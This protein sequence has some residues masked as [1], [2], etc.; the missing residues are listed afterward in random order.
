MA[1]SS[2]PHPPRRGLL[3]LVTVIAASLAFVCGLATPALARVVE[4]HPANQAFSANMTGWSTS[5][6]ATCT[7]VLVPLCSVTPQH[8]A[9][10]GNPAGALQ[11]RFTSLVT[12]LNVIGGTG[13]FTSDPFTVSQPSDS[14]ELRIDRLAQVADLL[15]LGG[16]VGWRVRLLDLTTPA[17]SQ[18]LVD[19]PVLVGDAAWNSRVLPV[20]TALVAGHQY[21]IAIQT[22]FSGTL[23]AIQ[24]WDVFYDNVALQLEV[25]ESP[26]IGTPVT[27]VV[28]ATGATLGAQVD[29]RGHA[30]TVHVEWGVTTA[31]GQQTAPQPIGSGSSPVAATADLSGLA[32]GTT[33]HYR[34]V[35][36]SLEGTTEGPDLTFTTLDP[37]RVTGLGTAAAAD[38]FTV[39]GQIDPRGF[40]TTYRVEYGTSASYGAQTAP[41]PAG[42]GTGDVPLSAPVTGLAPGTTYHWR[43]VATS[44]QGTFTGPDRT[45]TTLAPP[46]A[47]GFSSTPAEDRFTAHA[48]VDAN[49]VATT[50]TIEY[51]ATTAYGSTAP[52]AP[53]SGADPV[54]VDIPVTGLAAGTTYHWRVVAT[55]ADGT[56]TGPDQTVTTLAPPVI[57]APS[58]TRAADSFTARATIDPRGHA[59]TYRIEWGIGD[60]ANSTAAVAVP[61]PGQIAETVSGLASGTTYRWRVVA[62]SAQGTVVGATQTVT[63]LAP[64]AISALGE[65]A[66]TDQGFTASFAVD[67]R[68]AAA[69]VAVEYGTTAAYGQTAAADVAGTGPVARTVPISGLTPGTVIHWRV[70]AESAEGRTEGPDRTVTTLAPPVLS[71]FDAT[72]GALSFQATLQVDA[73]GFGTEV[74]V[75]YGTTPSYGAITGPVDAGDGGSPVAVSVPVTGLAQ[76]TTYHWRAVATSSQGT[77]TGPDQTVATI[78][79][80]APPA[81]GA[82]SATPG[83]G[84]FIASGSVDP[85]GHLTDVRVEYGPTAAYGA[86][87]DPVEAGSGAGPVG[88]EVPV[89]GLVPG[90]V[91]HWRIV[92][93]SAEGTVHGPDQTVTTLAPPAGLAP[94][95]PIPGPP[96][97]GGDPG[98]GTSPPAP[99]APMTPFGRCTIVGTDGP[100]RLTGTPGRDI[101]CGLGGG[102]VIRGLGGGD[103]IFGDAG[104]DVIDGGAGHDIIR[105]G[106]GR[107]IIAGGAGDDRILGAAGDDRLR[108]GAGRDRLDG[109]AG[110]DAVDGGAGN[111]QLVGGAGR[112]LLRGGAGDD[113][114]LGRAGDDR[115]EGGPGVDL[116]MGGPGDDRLIG[117]P[118][119]DRLNGGPGR[120][121]AVGAAGERL[122]IRVERR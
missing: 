34:V 72:P 25:D 70:V 30:T 52:G 35:A 4:T 29:P 83:A 42:S 48:T 58:S 31:Y 75:E 41:V 61:G 3:R 116:L 17:L 7:V 18:T 89:A 82:F 28:G 81:L 56:F 69:S 73:R 106:A 36:T 23:S 95:G 1:S 32:P 86:L 38:G 64:P 9:A 93:E 98:A 54:A 6:A 100:D 66:V 15:S 37:P 77:V 24:S 19:E 22:D 91:Y 119:R 12:L 59:T 63:T 85:R 33:Y 11:V 102:D 21:S 67:A 50:V 76:T 99:D 113:Q 65:T 103:V 53:L 87:T 2:T 101:I 8:A 104:D 20:P 114:L 108:G 88:V 97:A 79:A 27:P 45:V 92:A 68:G 84:A 49:G 16:G 96:P 14:A 43:L 51:G 118:G 10:T 120:D 110:D 46:T 117:G 5:P 112:D 80:A 121:T 47:S 74:R 94:S 39:T 71:A 13:S 107:D 115:L 55:S 78:S 111:D 109:G 62:E 40:A 122:V 26:V 90:A 57:S 105:G 60:F 44:D